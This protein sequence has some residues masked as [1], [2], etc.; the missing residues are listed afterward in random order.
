[1]EHYI[2]IDN[3]SLDHKVR[4]IDEDG[5]QN[6]SFSIANTLE[7]FE[8]LN[9]KL[10]GI[11]N[12]KI[13][14]E[15]PH[16]PLVDYLHAH[17][18]NLYSLNPLKIKRYKE[19][20][21]V[22]GNKNDDIDDNNDNIVL[23]NGKIRKSLANP[24]NP[25][26]FTPKAVQAVQ[27]KKDSKKEIGVN[28]KNRIIEILED[29]KDFVDYQHRNHKNVKKGDILNIESKTADLLIKSGKA[30]EIIN[31]NFSGGS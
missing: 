4:V 5:N 28:E 25:D 3:S 26:N 12:I 18:Y 29:L 16:G 14:F 11:K 21:K 9:K 27:P 8:E 24:A 30:K 20:I 31:R 1:M 7:G 6:L 15:L 10:S 19:S 13:G 17:K 22:S 2:G 23:Y